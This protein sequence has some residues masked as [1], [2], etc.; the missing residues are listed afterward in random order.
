MSLNEIETK[1]LTFLYDERVRDIYHPPHI[2]RLTD[3]TN[4]P[5]ER[6]ELIVK[7]LNLEGYVYTYYAPGPVKITPSGIDFVEGI[8]DEKR[9][10]KIR[11][12]RNDVLGALKS[13]HTDCGDKWTNDVHLSGIVGMDDRLYLYSI[14]DYLAQKNLLEVRRRARGSFHARISNFGYQSTST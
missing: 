2:D 3:L 1:I 10:G 5:H 8:F 7:F 13:V 9:L 12:D 4:L 14:V 6:V 11:Q